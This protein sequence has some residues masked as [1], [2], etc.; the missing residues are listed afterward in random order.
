MNTVYYTMLYIHITTLLITT[1]HTLFLP[2]GS[3]RLV[4]LC[5][6]VYLPHKNMHQPYLLAG[7]QKVLSSI[8]EPISSILLD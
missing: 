5:K 8:P 7:W 6:P 4:P 1:V 2:T 3:Y